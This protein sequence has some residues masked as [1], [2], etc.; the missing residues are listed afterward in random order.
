[1]VREAESDTSKYS[2]RRWCCIIDSK[3][4]AFCLFFDVRV[5]DANLIPLDDI[6]MVGLPN[7]ILK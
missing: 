3:K 4:P 2:Y 5:C 6:G 7:A 1:M